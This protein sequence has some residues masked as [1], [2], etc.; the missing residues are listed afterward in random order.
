MRLAASPYLQ[1]ARTDHWFKNVF[2]LLGVLVAFL[3][4]PSME[5]RRLLV[6]LPA[7]LATCLVASSNYV[8]NEILDAP[9]DRQHP[10]KMNRP[11]AAGRVDLKLAYLEWL[12]LAAVGFVLGFAVNTPFALAAISLWVMALVYNVPPLRAKELPYFDVLVES[13]NNPIR[14][15]LG[16]FALLD[17]RLPPVS[18]LLAYWALGAF[19]MGTKRFAEL[20]SIGDP[21]RAARYRRSFRYYTEERLLVSI[22]FYIAACSFLGG[23]FIVRCKLELV[24]F[25]PFV[26]GHF[27][28]YLKLGLAPNSPVQHP[29]RLYKERGFFLYTLFCFALF[30]VLMFSEVRVLYEVFNFPAART[31]PLWVFD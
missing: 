24:L 27:A 7:A 20:R 14:L 15:L 19:F 22:L 4:A 18:L 29:E 31:P 1:I 3:Y 25:V 21:A 16:W 2:M 5:W 26:A 12:L 6:L 17:D 30:V 28:Y 10:V 9:T 13:V 23:V 8:L 11:V